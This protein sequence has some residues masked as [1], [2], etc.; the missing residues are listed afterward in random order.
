MLLD[1]IDID[2]LRYLQEDSS[3]SNL[4]LSK[5]I[6][7]SP[8]TCLTRTKALRSG[9][10]ITGNVAIVDA[11]NVGLNTTAFTLVS[12]KDTSS[13]KFDE[14]LRDIR[15]RDE[16]LECYTITGNYA[17]LLKVV[18]RDVKS[19][20]EFLTQVLMANELVS[21]IHTN[22]VMGREKVTT[23]LPLESIQQ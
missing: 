12:I 10:F 13:S 22:I 23:R 2:I 14:F 18:V 1:K 19:Y 3:I 15:L 17:I 11:E 9:G 21:Q 5:K 6:G 16:V 4:D 8:S 7:V 20:R